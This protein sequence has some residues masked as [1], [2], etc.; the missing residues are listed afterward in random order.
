MFVAADRSNREI[1][2][3]KKIRMD[4]EKDGF[5]ITALREI[6]ILSSVF[7]ENIIRLREI[8]RSKRLNTNIYI[9]I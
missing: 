3:L 9:L 8:I 7:H 5:P 6:R 2:A 4:S 1:V